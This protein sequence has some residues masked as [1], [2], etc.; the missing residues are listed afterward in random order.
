MHYVLIA[1]HSPDICPSS[2]AT[3]RKLMQE[4]TPDIPAIA[5]KAGVKIVS[6]PFVSREHVTVA[7]TEAKSGE[8]LDQFIVESRLAQWN[9]VRVLPSKTMQEGIAEIEQMPIVY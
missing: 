2:N 1:T 6:G 7:V 4:T 3:T 8:D 5:E 9:S